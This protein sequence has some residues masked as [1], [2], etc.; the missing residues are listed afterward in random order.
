MG[1]FIVLRKAAIKT[2]LE[3]GHLASPHIPNSGIL[4]P[5]LEENLVLSDSKHE[6][7]YSAANHNDLYALHACSP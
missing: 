5:G 3:W 4:Y 6:L 7:R 2:N 1:V